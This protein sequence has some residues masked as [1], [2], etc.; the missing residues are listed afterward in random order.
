MTVLIVDNPSE[1]G[2][3]LIVKELASA[4]VPMFRMDMA[5]FPSA[6]DFRASFGVERWEGVLTKGERS[7]DL[8]AIR[9]VYWNRPGA[10]TFPGL[11][12]SDE[13]YARDAA[14]IGFGGVLTSL[15][16]AYLNHPAK[17][18]A[19]E[20]RP[21]QLQVASAAGL[22]IPQTLVTTEAEAVRRFSRNVGGPVVT[23][24]LGAPVAA[25]T[26]GYECL[27]VREP[28]PD[29]LEGI[30]STAHLFQERIEKDFEVRAVFVGDECFSARVDAVTD[31]ARIG[32]DRRSGCD[33]VKLT[34]VETP[35]DVHHA[36][37]R[38]AA[39]MGLACFTADF[40]VRPSGQ[41]VFL[42]ADPRGRWAWTNSPDLPV[43]KAIA[44]VLEEWCD[45]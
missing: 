33:S 30:A 16:A 6:L 21:R 19:A 37:R 10:F 8:S 27:C 13:R 42:E 11:S 41:W 38:Y 24:A 25:R 43:A 3:D 5:D 7:V 15:D 32:I 12:E 23:R 34:P 29:A 28:D 40:V 20:F 44:G 17:S 9:A 39:V 14:R 36:L 22:A 31:Q 1:P 18:T 45:L 26:A 35:R 4:G 2:T